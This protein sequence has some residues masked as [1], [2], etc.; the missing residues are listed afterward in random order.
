MSRIIDLFGTQVDIDE[1]TYIEED[2]S[3]KKSL[4]MVHLGWGFKELIRL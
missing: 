4:L 2:Y 3:N 1:I